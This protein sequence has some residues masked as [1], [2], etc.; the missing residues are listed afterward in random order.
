MIE[1]K[2]WVNSPLLNNKYKFALDDKL[3]IK[4]NNNKR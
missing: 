4:R 3:I 1:K 2:K